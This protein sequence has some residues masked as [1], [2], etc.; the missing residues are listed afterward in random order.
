MNILGIETSC[1]E[2]SA[3]VVVDGRHVLSNVISSQLE[4]HQPYGGIVPEL[5]ARAQVTAIIPVVQEALTLA[6][7]PLAEID[8]IAVT[9]GPG[10][11]GS[12]LVGVNFAKT[13]AYARDLP[14]IPVNHLESH[15]Y[16]NWLSRSLEEAERPAFPLVSLL[17][18]G[19]HTELILMTDL[20]RYQVLGRTLDDAAGEAFDKGARLLGLG[21]PGGPAIQR[22]A[23]QGN[24]EAVT[25]PR[26]WL[27][28][29]HDFSFSGLKTALLRLAEPYRLP[30]DGPK[31]D[32][33]LPFAPH[34]PPR[35]RDDFPAADLAASFQ[36][37]IADVLAVKTARAAAAYGV[38]S[39]LLAG[40][41]AANALL[42][43]RLA[44]EIEKADMDPPTLFIPPLELCTDN[45]AMVAGAGYYGLRRGNQAGWEFDVEARLP[46]TPR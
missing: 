32:P 3:A 8:A 36:R 29:S 26:A 9:N 41:V 5:A 38:R 46:L 22:L 20:G 42:R 33:R 44:E 28:D 31:P 6:R 18:S 16:A 23:E 43:S 17:V 10:L 19:G 11:A 4:V 34:R 13:V 7:V 37:A 15:I 12:L 14:L 40:G 24:H 45:A 2:T 1:D 27:D 21:Y 30:D 25:L 35:Y 39:V